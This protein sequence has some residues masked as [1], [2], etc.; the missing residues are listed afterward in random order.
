MG[1]SSGRRRGAGRVAVVMGGPPARHWTA[2][3]ARVSTFY[4]GQIPLARAIVSRQHAPRAPLLLQSGV[5]ESL[6]GWPLPRLPAEG[7]AGARLE[8]RSWL[9]SAMGRLLARLAG[10]P[11]L[12]RRA[13]R[14]PLSSRA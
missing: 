10:A 2:S 9:R 8:R 13:R 1:A 4:L 3:G 12:V 5:P 6:L 14:L 7:R 11:P